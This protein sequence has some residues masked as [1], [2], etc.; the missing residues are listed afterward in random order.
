MK[1]GFQH[2]H[3]IDDVIT[4][5]NGDLTAA[6]VNNRPSTVT[7]FNTPVNQK[8]HIKYDV[9]IFAQDS[10]T[11]KRLTVNPGVRW[12]LFNAYAPE[13]SLPP[14]Q[15]APSRFYSEQPNLPNFNDVALRMSGA[16][17]VF[18][19]GKTAIKASAGQYYVQITGFWT[20]VHANSGLSSDTRTWL[21][22][23]L[24]AAGNACSGVAARPIAIASCSSTRSAPHRPAPSASARTATRPEY[25]APEQLGILD[26]RAAAAHADADGRGRVGH[27]SWR[28]LQ[29]SDRTLISGADYTSFTTP[30]PNFSNDPT[31]TGASIPTKSSRCITSTPRRDPCSAARS[32]TRTPRRTSRKYNG[33][34]FTFSTRFRGTNLFGGFTADR[35]RASTAPE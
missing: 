17:D 35:N 16:Y 30:M 8:A 28:E 6:Y 31:L 19:D 2:V 21:D 27:R 15:F 18:G 22:C 25:P 4:E 32:S 5:R 24:N 14:G 23:Q 26:R 9:G 10:W 1:V 20:K 11:L 7:V 12:Q 29:V 3:G 34:E 33:F 13:V